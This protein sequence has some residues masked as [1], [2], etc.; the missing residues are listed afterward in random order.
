MQQFKAR[1][2]TMDDKKDREISFL[3][4]KT[5]TRSHNHQSQIRACEASAIIVDRKTLAACDNYLISSSEKEDAQSGPKERKHNPLPTK[6][7]CKTLLCMCR[8]LLMLY[9][10]FLC[11]VLSNSLVHAISE[12]KLC[13]DCKSHLIPLRVSCVSCVG[14][15]GL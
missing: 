1:T 5:K 13:N 8:G 6:E 9:C 10:S 12:E 2:V 7:N 11:Q 14:A 3:C 15:R 4:E